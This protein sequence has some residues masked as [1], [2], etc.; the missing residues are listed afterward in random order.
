MFLSIRDRSD[1][2]KGGGFLGFCS[3]KVLSKRLRVVDAVNSRRTR[4]DCGAVGAAKEESYHLTL[5]P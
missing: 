5:L 3:T 2:N 4:L 1:R